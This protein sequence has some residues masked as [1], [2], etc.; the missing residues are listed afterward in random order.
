MST[1]RYTRRTPATSQQPATPTARGEGEQRER[2]HGWGPNNDTVRVVWAPGIPF[3]SFLYPLTISSLSLGCKLHG[4]TP[5][6]TSHCSQGGRHPFPPPHE[7]TPT[8]ASNCLRG[9]SPSVSPGA[10]GATAAPWATSPTTAPPTY[11]VI[12]HG[13]TMTPPRATVRRVDPYPRPGPPTMTTT[14]RRRHQLLYSKEP[15]IAGLLRRRSW[16]IPYR[17]PYETTPTP[18]ATGCG[19][20]PP[21]YHRAQGAPLPFRPTVPVTTRHHVP[22]YLE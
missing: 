9:G 11:Y 5:T 2:A 7:T 17:T 15:A 8:P 12:W 13:A 6:A 20:D 19:V 16:R 14:P 18:R 3:F 22:R 4:T 1:P 21:L 10:G